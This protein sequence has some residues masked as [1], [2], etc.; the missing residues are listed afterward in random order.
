MIVEVNNLRLYDD[1]PGF[2]K[3]TD[4]I[5]KSKVNLL[6]YLSKSFPDAEFVFY[7]ILGEYGLIEEI[8]DL[9]KGIFHRYSIVIEEEEKDFNSSPINNIPKIKVDGKI[10]TLEDVETI[11][12]IHAERL[13]N[14]VCNYTNC[15]YIIENFAAKTYRDNVITYTVDVTPKNFVESNII[16]SVDEPGKKY[17]LLK[18]LRGEEICF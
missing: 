3:F 8:D 9:L 16:S 17:F 18:L 12:L 1:Y 11:G 6:I 2:G 14:F 15:F 10:Q 13:E 7:N 5:F 4:H